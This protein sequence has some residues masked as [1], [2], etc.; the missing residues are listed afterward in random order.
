V[1]R[2]ALLFLIM[3]F[4]VFGCGGYDRAVDPSITPVSTTTGKADD[5][6]DDPCRQTVA[7]QIFGQ[8]KS[9]PGANEACVVASD[10]DCRQ[11]LFCANTG[12]CSRI[13]T[14]DGYRCLPGKDADCQ[15]S[16]GC[17]QFGQCS[18]YPDHTC[19]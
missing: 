2:A 17:L 4:V 11:A 9:G 15:Q 8:C 1:D 3:V 18:W 7:C 16:Y 6:G 14:T 10:A 12:Y 19:R 5:P 13:K